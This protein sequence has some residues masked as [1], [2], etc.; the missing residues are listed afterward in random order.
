MRTEISKAVK[1]NFDKIMKQ[2]LPQFELA[3]KTPHGPVYRSHLHGMNCFVLLQLS[4]NRDEEAFTLELACSRESRYPWSALLM[5]PVASSNGVARFRLPELYREQWKAKGSK[6][7][8]WWIGPHLTRAE[9]TDRLLSRVRAGVGHL[10][11]RDGLLSIGDL[12]GMVEQ[13]VSDAVQKLATYGLQFFET[14]S[15]ADNACKQ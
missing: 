5:P 1:A 13:Q 6:S 8:W 2:A 12:L 10:P 4:K 9:K 14:F 7:S 3:E 11:D 15:V